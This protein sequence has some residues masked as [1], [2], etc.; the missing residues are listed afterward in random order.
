[1]A[2]IELL[3]IPFCTFFYEVVVVCFMV[4]VWCSDRGSCCVW[5]RKDRKAKEL[6]QLTSVWIKSADLRPESLRWRWNTWQHVGER[7]S[8]KV[9]HCWK[10]ELIY[11]WAN[12]YTVVWKWQQ[13]NN[14]FRL[15][16]PPHKTTPVYRHKF[17]GC[18]WEDDIQALKLKDLSSVTKLV[19]HIDKH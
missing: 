8:L 14:V 9:R 11:K 7:R 13:Y 18:I 12:C 10:K 1:M 19:Q 17:S 3:L 5:T 2:V 16:S 15:S 6:I 4:S